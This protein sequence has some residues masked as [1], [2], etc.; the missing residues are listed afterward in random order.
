MVWALGLSSYLSFSEVLL[1]KDQ[2]KQK[3]KGKEGE[4]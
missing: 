1:T 2:T 4:D 3:A